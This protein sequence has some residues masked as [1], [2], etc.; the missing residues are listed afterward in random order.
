MKQMAPWTEPIGS[1]RAGNIRRKL[2]HRHK[3]APGHAACELWF[4][5]TK[6]T[7]AHLGVNS[8]GSDRVRV[9]PERGPGPLD[10]FPG[11]GRVDVICEHRPKRQHP[12]E[13]LELDLSLESTPVHGANRGFRPRQVPGRNRRGSAGAEPGDL[14]RIHDREQA[15]IPGVGQ[16]NHALDGRQTELG[17]V[18]G[19][20]RRQLFICARISLAMS[21][22]RASRT[23]WK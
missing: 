23:L 12:A 5:N 6:K 8:V 18:A 21:N 22:A 15:A 13:A 4:I 10:E 9:H 11:P 20:D 7:L 14:D 17:P 19:V 2:F 16:D 3:A 1:D